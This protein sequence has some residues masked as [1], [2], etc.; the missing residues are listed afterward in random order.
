VAAK[1]SMLMALIVITFRR[2]VWPIA[3]DAL[4]S[5]DGPA[6]L[7]TVARFY[8]GVGAA[9]I[10]VLSALSPILVRILTP[11][12]YHSAYPVVGILAWQSLFYGFSLIAAAGMWKT[13]KTVWAPFTMA[14][15]AC[16]N[17]A[18]NIL[19]IPAF[20][21][22]GAA[23]STAASFLCWVLGDLIISERY[24][25]VRYPLGV[26]SLEVAIGAA[27]VWSVLALM[28]YGRSGWWVA[29][30][31]LAAVA[32][33]SFLAGRCERWLRTNAPSAGRCGP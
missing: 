4:Q 26:M 33:L 11:E 5:D 21:V 23:V 8:L 3:L 32:S 31:T 19:L 25:P 24:W 12:A 18:L 13:E 29:G 22:I 7:R 20:G 30:V 10:V 1:F 28:Q 16:L 6:F 17:I 9:G 2:A 14:F 15:A 27:A